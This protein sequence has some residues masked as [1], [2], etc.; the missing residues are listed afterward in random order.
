VVALN[1]ELTIGNLLE[2]MLER[3]PGGLIEVV[4]KNA[5]W[6]RKFSSSAKRM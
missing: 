4:V 2:I 3:R 6:I 5:A 1:L